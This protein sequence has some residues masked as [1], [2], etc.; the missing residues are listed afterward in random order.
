V[1]IGGVAVERKGTL[2]VVSARTE[3]ETNP[4]QDER[5]YVAVPWEFADLISPTPHAFLLTALVSAGIHGET[6]VQLDEPVSP[7][8]SEGAGDALGILSHWYGDPSVAIEAP[9]RASSPTVH[10][11]RGAGLFFSGGVDSLGS[12]QRNLELI[13]RDS[14]EAITHCI[15]VDWLGPRSVDALE[16]KLRTSH[17]P[18]VK[19]L[20]RATEAAGTT[21]VPVVTNLRC[22]ENYDFNR[23]WMR[24]A[25]GALLCAVAHALSGGI[26]RILIAST[27]D[28]PHLRPWGSHPLLDSRFSSEDLMVVHDEVHRSRLSKLEAIAAWDAA[29][30]C[31]IVCTDWMTPREGP[32]NCGKCEKCLRTLASLKAV[33]V[34]RDLPTFPEGSLTP[35]AVRTRARWISTDYKFDQW[36]EIE[37]M[38]HSRGEIAL[39]RAV[40]S[41]LRWSL[42]LRLDRRHFDERGA[43]SARWLKKVIHHH[44]SVPARAG[45]PP[46]LA[47]VAEP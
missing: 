43:R 30:D 13:P 39:A 18:I 21:F 25:H 31:I 24:R 28:V 1:K 45:D 7:L 12:L 37:P 47:P 3:W 29:L 15:N 17:E 11:G 9:H 40:R 34:E 42:P 4:A 46:T 26:Q 6:R 27:N 20:R 2:C 35:R 32:P 14:A 36:A 23:D 38:L 44:P 33:G 19:Y 10:P 22:L 41:N 16:G 8:L 5:L